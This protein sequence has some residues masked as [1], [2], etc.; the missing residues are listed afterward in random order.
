MSPAGI[1]VNHILLF[2]IG[3]WYYLIFPII[4]GETIPEIGGVLW[5]SLYINISDSKLTFY[6][7]LLFGLYFVFMLSNMLPISSQSEKYYVFSKC[8]LYKWQIISFAYFL[9]M[10]YKAKSDLFKGYTE[11]NGKRIMWE[12]CLH[13][14]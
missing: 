5:E 1:I 10:A 6:V 9:Y 8:T 13:C 4:V 3:F 7:I 12:R 2:S 11:N 14:Y